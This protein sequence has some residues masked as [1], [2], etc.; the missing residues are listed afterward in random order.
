M[1]QLLMKS[2]WALTISALVFMLA[3]CGTTGGL[4]RDKLDQTI[5][6][7]QA[8]ATQICSFVPAV[9]TVSAILS[10]TGVPYVGMVPSIAEQICAAVTRRSGAAVPAVQVNGKMI[11]VRGRF[12]SR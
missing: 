12:V 6:D 8:A 5:A 3:G 10:A 11:P 9:S 1:K 7:I 2:R 4:N